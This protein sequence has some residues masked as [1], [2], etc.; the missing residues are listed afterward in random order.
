MNCLTKKGK[1]LFKR[2]KTGNISI[3]TGFGFVLSSFQ[4][5]S[6]LHIWQTFNALF[7]IRCTVKYL[8]ETGSQFQLMQHFE[9]L[10]IN[11]PPEN[12]SSTSIGTNIEI[13]NGIETAAN[14][15]SKSI[16]LVDGSKFD[17]FF[18]AIVNLLVIIPVK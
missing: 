15:S 10:P 16:R 3:N 14:E 13:E 7:I 11:V 8:I 18:D 1:T 2:K 4:T 17:S 9:A 12:N 5:S 6:S